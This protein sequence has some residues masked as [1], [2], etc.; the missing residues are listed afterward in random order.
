MELRS[1][2]FSSKK[3]Y[4]NKRRELVSQGH[5]VAHSNGAMT[6]FHPRPH[7]MRMI[8]MMDGNSCEDLCWK[9][10]VVERK[11][12]YLEV[13]Q[14]TKYQP[15]YNECEQA[16]GRVEVSGDKKTVTLH[17]NNPCC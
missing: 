6:K 10:V 12:G 1:K 11:S 17:L 8:D 2:D 3:D 7:A 9:W 5:V 14:A 4:H 16:F 15:E 13:Y